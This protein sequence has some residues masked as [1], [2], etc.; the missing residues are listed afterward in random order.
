MANDIKQVLDIRPG[1]GM[2]V[3]QSDE[4]QRNWTEKGWDWATKHGNY[5]RSR[6][7]LNF[8]VVKGGII[9]PVDKSRTITGRM[10]DNLRER[11]ITD[12]N[13]KLC[14][15]KYRT[16][17]NIIFGGS[18]ER[19]HEIA[20]GNQRVDLTHGAD[21][22]HIRRNKDIERWA[23]DVYRF[24]CEHWGEENVI[25]FYVHLDELNPHVHCTVIPE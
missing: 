15:P 5:D 20:F 23:L 19:M 12:P 14:E 21:N 3:G 1:K 11:G 18:R 10:A 16:V 4:H 24:A 9:Q 2:S 25:G 7:H 17:A 6:D 13:A 8:E 22:S